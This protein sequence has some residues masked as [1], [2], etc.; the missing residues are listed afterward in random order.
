MIAFINYIA[1]RKKLKFHPWWL[2]LMCN[3]FMY[4]YPYPYPYPYVILYCMYLFSCIHLYIICSVSLFCICICN[5]ILQS[6]HWPLP[7]PLTNVLYNLLN[8]MI[9]ANYVFSAQSSV[10][11]F[12][13]GI[14]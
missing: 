1:T 11:D 9:C 6:N 12:L 13:T 14:T 7:R 10:S 8:V 4:P 5:T 2:Y 3:T